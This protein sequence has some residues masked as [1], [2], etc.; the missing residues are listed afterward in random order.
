MFKVLYKNSVHTVYD[1]TVSHHDI[2]HPHSVRWPNIYAPTNA[3]FLIA[4]EDGHFCWVNIEESREYTGGE[5]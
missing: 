4:G 3:Y 1:V 5:L 2:I